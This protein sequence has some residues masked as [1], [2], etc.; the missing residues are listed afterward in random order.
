MKDVSKSHNR[1][2]NWLTILI[3]G[4]DDRRREV[5]IAFAPQICGIASCTDR[6]CS[7]ADRSWRRHRPAF[8]HTL[9]GQSLF[10]PVPGLLVAYL[11]IGVHGSVGG[12]LLAPHVQQLF[13]PP[14]VASHWLI[15]YCV[16]SLR[17]LPS[18]IACTITTSPNVGLLL[19]GLLRIVC[20]YQ[21]MRCFRIARAIIIWSA[22]VLLVAGW[23]KS[24]ADRNRWLTENGPYS[25]ARRRSL[26]L[27][28]WLSL[29]VT[30]ETL[31]W[32]R[33]C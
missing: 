23:P 32:H 30:Q 19:N 1:W 7:H 2:F 28:C 25:L 12:A 29:L 33:L 24:L 11:P 31:V 4:D 8:Q 10:W 3:L 14:L 18:G 5:G 6:P 21:R 16:L 26:L 22:V 27:A 9:R 15:G 20:D 17:V 13:W